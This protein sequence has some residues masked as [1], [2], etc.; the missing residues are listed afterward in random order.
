MAIDGLFIAGAGES[1]VFNQLSKQASS[2]ACQ[3]AAHL[4]LITF[5]I[6]GANAL[7][8]AFVNEA[9]H[10]ICASSR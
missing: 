9:R 10:F 8:N 2:A 3:A 1:G 4:P 7:A 6:S 5:G